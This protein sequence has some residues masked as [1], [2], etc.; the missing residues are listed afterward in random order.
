MVTP[1]SNASSKVTNQAPPLKGEEAFRKIDRADK[2]FVTESD[3][4]SAIV[5]FSPEGLNLSQ[6]ETQSIAKA[7]FA[8]LDADVDGK[9]TLSEFKDAAPKS[10]AHGGPQGA[11]PSGP[12]QGPPSGAGA[13]AGAAGSAGAK[14]GASSGSSKSYDPADVNKDGTVSELERLAYATKQLTTAT[15]N[16]DSTRIDAAKAYQSV[17]GDA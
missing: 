15:A 3:L 12:P 4:A 11:R 17:G 10:S 7:A 9:V 16:T 5:Q 1:I 13:G 2:G 14:G 8:K 6:A